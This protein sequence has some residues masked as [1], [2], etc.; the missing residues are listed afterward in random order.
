MD[1]SFSHLTLSEFHQDEKGDQLIDSAA[2]GDIEQVQAWLQ[3]GANKDAINQYGETALIF[4]AS[5]GHTDV[6]VHLLSVGANKEAFNLT[7]ETALTFAADYDHA[8]VIEK[9]ILSGANKEATNQDGRTALMFSAANGHAAALSQLIKAGANIEALDNAHESAISYAAMHRREAFFFLLLNALPSE[10]VNVLVAQPNL[11]QAQ[12]IAL[13]RQ[14]ISR[15]KINT[16]IIF[17]GMFS[18]KTPKMPLDLMN[19]ILDFIFPTWLRARQDTQIEEI[20]QVQ[21][22]LS[23]V[24]PVIFS[25]GK[26]HCALSLSNDEEKKSPKGN[27]K[28][29]R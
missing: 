15:A 12:A 18:G 1:S 20:E 11:I 19:P 21:Q 10:R 16:V 26:E 13:F 23:I 17:M 22:L 25:R 6:V 4:A 9:L 5:K 2:M 7:G 28:P 14:T 3:A 24:Q 27:N 8:D 29:H